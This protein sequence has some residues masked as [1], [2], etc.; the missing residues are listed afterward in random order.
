MGILS[1]V[2]LHFVNVSGQRRTVF[3]VLGSDLD[4]GV[5]N[6]VF[7]E[8]VADPQSK[9]K[10]ATEMFC[11]NWVPSFAKVFGFVMSWSS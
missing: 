11:P 9:K 1:G 5:S 10:Q 3:C 8:R 2:R 6:Q 4:G 7:K